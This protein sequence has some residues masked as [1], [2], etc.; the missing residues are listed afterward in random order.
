MISFINHR[1]FEQLF[2]DSTVVSQHFPLLLSISRKKKKKE[3]QRFE[4]YLS[5]KKNL[6]ITAR[7]L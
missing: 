6:T 3:K 4:N 1:L 2:K 7:K 5:I